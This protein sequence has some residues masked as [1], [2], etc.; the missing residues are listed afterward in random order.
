MKNCLFV[1]LM[2]SSGAS[3]VVFAEEIVKTP[4]SHVCF[5]E[6]EKKYNHSISNA[7]K[8]FFIF[9]SRELQLD[10]PKCVLL[11]LVKNQTP[12]PDEKNTVNLNLRVLHEELIDRK[13][14][15]DQIVNTYVEEGI[16][17]S[18]TNLSN[19]DVESDPNVE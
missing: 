13:H 4:E 11:G 2:I 7:I 9:F 15:F 19:P 3:G 17:K 1:F 8:V 10:F 18:V 12:V 5:T 16:C 14:I 6:C